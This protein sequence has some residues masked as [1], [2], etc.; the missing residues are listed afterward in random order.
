H[1]HDPERVGD[2]Q[3]R[4]PVPL[5]DERVRASHLHH[6]GGAGS[7]ASGGRV[8]V[9]GSVVD[10]DAVAGLGQWLD[11]APEL[12]PVPAPAVDEICGGAI[13]FLAVD[14]AAH[15]EAVAGQRER[16]PSCGFPTTAALCRG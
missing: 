6:P 4:G 15:D 12:L 3:R 8:A 2:G 7:V 1:G 5:D 16:L 13:A 10:D 14:T 11:E 9:A